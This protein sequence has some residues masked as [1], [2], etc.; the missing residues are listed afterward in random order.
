MPVDEQELYKFMGMA[1]NEFTNINSSITNLGVRIGELEKCLYA[2]KTNG[3]K[4]PAI[5]MGGGG[6]TTVGII[7]IIRMVFLGS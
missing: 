6:I 1:T 7:E 2:S 3:W 5:Y 4:K